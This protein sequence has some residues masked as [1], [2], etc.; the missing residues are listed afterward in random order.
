MFRLGFFDLFSLDKTGDEAKA[1]EWL[2]KAAAKGHAGAMFLVGGNYRDGHVV[3]RDYEKARKWFEKAVATDDLLYAD[4][5][6]KAL[7]K[8]SKLSKR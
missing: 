8:L 6:R 1:H 3:K 2:E 7:K 4:A 5:A